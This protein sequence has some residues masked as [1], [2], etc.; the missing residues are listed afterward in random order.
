LAN[1]VVTYG[2][3][4]RAILASEE[5]LREQGLAKGEVIAVQIDNPIM[6]VIVVAALYRLGIVS[7]SI[8]DPAALPASGLVVSAVLTDG[9]SPPAPIVR[10]IKV[11]EDW[12]SGSRQPLTANE[13]PAQFEDD[14]VCRIILSSGT[15]GLPKPLAVTPRIM[16]QR[17][18]TRIFVSA[19]A[20]CERVLVL[21]GMVSQIGWASAVISLCCGGTVFFAASATL[22][23]QMIDLYGI[24]SAI[25]TAQQI[26]DLVKSQKE[27][28]IPCHTLRLLQTGGGIV[29]D[30][31]MAE[32]QA[33]L[34]N[35][36]L[37][38]YGSTEVGIAA[39]AP[40]EALKGISGAVGLLAPWARLQFVDDGGNE[41]PLG[42]EGVIRIWTGAHCRV[43]NPALTRF[44]TADDEWFY[45]GDVGRLLDNGVLVLTGR[46]S[47]IINL[48]G[49]KIAPDIVEQIVMA[50]GD[51][52]EVAA[53]GMINQLGL[54]EI[55]LAI[56]PTANVEP[57]EVLA[58]ISRTHPNLTPGRVVTVASIPRNQAGKIMRDQLRQE[59]LRQHPSEQRLP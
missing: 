55:W 51:M 8:E 11:Q 37:C 54:E 7:V 19:I 31:L 5:R 44:R 36:V 30:S 52:R 47:E 40:G 23:I 39:F 53:V 10:T 26:R 45:P 18:Y 50:R 2:I 59:L 4:A 43:F 28:S 15:T 24:S 56:V 1:S 41:V 14:E 3:V 17:I 25:A 32:T 42:G 27:L 33:A 12:F 21:P 16:D 13:Q 34:C 20:S 6:H 22:A 58:R 48:G 35:R 29:S 38:R 57:N 46:T 9:D 49:L